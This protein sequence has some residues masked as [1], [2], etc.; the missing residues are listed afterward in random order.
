MIT[1]SSSAEA[2]E[3]LDR[4]QKVAA[5]IPD[6]GLFAEKAWRVSPESFPLTRGEVKALE[7]LGPVFNRFQQACDLIYRRSQKGSLPPWIARYLN[8]GKPDSLLRMGQSSACL[9]A[10]PQV[11][12]PDLILTESGFVATELDSVPGGM[13]LTA[14]LGKIYHELDP[15]AEI[16]GGENGMTSG[17]ASI[18]G[19]DGADV[20]VSEE[21]SDYRPEMEWLSAQLGNAWQ[22]HAAEPYEASG[23]AVYRFF[24]LFDLP[25]LPGGLRVGEAASKGQLH[26]TSPFKPW[27]EEKMW[28][29]LFWSR[30]LQEVWRR[31]LR[32]SNWRRLQSVFPMSWIIDPA[33][34]PHHAVIPELNIQSFSELREFSQSKRDLVLKLSGFNE[35]AWG[36][37]SVTIG[38][39]V[40]QDEWA[41]AV[42]LAIDAFETSP[43][44]MQRFHSGKLVSH[45]WWNPDSDRLEMMEGR[46]RLCPYYFVEKGTHEVRLGGVLATICPSDKKV[47]HGM[48]EAIM[49]PCRIED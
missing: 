39:D 31:E 16:V 41:S 18:F 32:D 22:V 28:A 6:G 15:G 44:V 19:E 13:G 23:R 43:Y 12:R 27:L 40:P 10:L 29:A 49:V 33:E 35:K 4:A 7:R 37:R 48:T 8:L 38:H 36:S 26:L 1:R 34:V 20:L 9:E 2:S 30:P 24:E 25:N 21:A 17:F 3:M 14:W 47:L 46:A 11:I 5:A 45:P 42:D